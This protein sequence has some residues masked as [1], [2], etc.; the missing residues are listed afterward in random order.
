MA[1]VAPDTTPEDIDF[2]TA[3]FREAVETLVR[4]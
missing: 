3:V 1:L 4:G 2:H